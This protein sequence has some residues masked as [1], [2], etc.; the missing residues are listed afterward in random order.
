[1]PQSSHTMAAQ[2]AVPFLVHVPSH[3]SLPLARQSLPGAHG[4]PSDAVKA[5]YFI[6]EH[7]RV[8][9]LLVAPA[10][11]KRILDSVREVVALHK[12]RNVFPIQLAV[13]K[14][15]MQGTLIRR[16][17]LRGC[18][19]PGQELRLGSRGAVTGHACAVSKSALLCVFFTRDNSVLNPVEQPLSAYDVLIAVGVWGGQ[20]LRFHGRHEALH[21]G[22]RGDSR[23]VH[24]L[25]R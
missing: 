18:V 8:S 21:C 7:L 14:V 4:C 13:T 2:C 11:K 24:T 15:S 25:W 16:Q 3:P 17:S 19:W 1:M 5:C 9:K 23:V 12:N 6:I 22:G 10:G 20:R